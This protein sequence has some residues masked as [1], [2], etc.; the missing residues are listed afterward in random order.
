MDLPLGILPGVNDDALF[1]ELD[2][3]DL[4][5]ELAPVDVGENERSL[6]ETAFGAEGSYEQTTGTSDPESRR[7]SANVIRGHWKLQVRP[8]NG[9]CTSFSGISLC[10]VTCAGEAGEGPSGG[11]QVLHVTQ[12]C[13]HG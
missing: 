5:A 12:M 3:L 2:D 9:H 6:Q 1:E 11:E 13:L 8:S 10:V 4:D 7:G